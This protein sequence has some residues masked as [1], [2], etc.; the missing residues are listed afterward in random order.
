MRQF[1]LIGK[2]LKHSFS[3]NY[4]SEK[5]NKEGIQNSEYELF[6]LD[7]IAEFQNLVDHYSDT[8]AGLNVT[9]P[10]KKEVMDFLDELDDNAAEIGAV[11]TIKVLEDGR[12]KGYN[13]D[14]LGFI[15]SLQ[16]GWDLS[17]KKALV[18]GTGGASEAIKKALKDLAIPFQSVSRKAS[19]ASIS[20]D[21]VNTGD[22]VQKHQL[23]INT[24]PLGTYPEVDTKP[25]L[26]YNLLSDQHLLFDLVYNPAIT[27]FLQEGLDAG[28]KIK[29]GHTM[30]I[31]QA[32]ASWKIWND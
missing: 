26:P 4:F 6:E 7:A 8:L 2:T 15:N 23:I 25:L 20:Y 10:Y 13:T 1:G 11:N 24:T 22:W 12:L 18:L 16:E 27:A 14:Y 32:E 5:F 3:K 28:A 31:G 17:N 9:I 21:E 19:E 29:N 30:L